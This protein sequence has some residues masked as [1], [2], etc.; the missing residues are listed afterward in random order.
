MG[1]TKERGIYPCEIEGLNI[2]AK[3]LTNGQFLIQP[4]QG[5]RFCRFLTPRV[6]PG[7]IM[8]LPFRKL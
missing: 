7:L 4:F 5:C 3:H 2:S 6:A 1:S 8:L